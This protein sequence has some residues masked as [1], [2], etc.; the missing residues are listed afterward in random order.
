VA[1]HG[2]SS[3]VREDVIDGFVV[4]LLDAL[5]DDLQHTVEAEYDSTMDAQMLLAESA[6]T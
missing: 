3:T 6:R 5:N 1:G 2:V 4:E